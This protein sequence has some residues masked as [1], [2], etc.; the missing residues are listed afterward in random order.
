MGSLSLLQGIFLTQQSKLGLLHCRRTLHQ[1]NYQGSPQEYEAWRVMLLY[2]FAGCKR[3]SITKRKGQQMS[4]KL[5]DARKYEEEKGKLIVA[6]DRPAFHLS[7]RVGWMNDPNGFSYYDG[8][9]HM[10]YQYYPYDSVWGPMHWGHAVSEDL[11]H[12]SYLPAVMAP[13]MPYDRDGCYSGCAVTLA[14]GRQMLM[15]TGRSLSSMKTVKSRK[16]RRRTWL[17]ETA[18][19]M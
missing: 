9:Y 11:I 18:P 17:L 8:R 10:F 7:A 2:F 14:D 6:A 15:Y 1:L 3:K 19:T 12:W 13:D 4:Q 5:K 16:S